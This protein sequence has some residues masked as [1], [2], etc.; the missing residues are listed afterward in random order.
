MMVI[1]SED[2]I[3]RSFF[4]NPDNNS[5]IDNG[6]RHRIFIIKA[7][8]DDHNKIAKDPARI[9]LYALLMTINTNKSLRIMIL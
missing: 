3:G 5:T 1:N 2:M 8:K 9:K 6:E 7:I 4:S